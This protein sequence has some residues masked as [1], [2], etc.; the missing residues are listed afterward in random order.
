MSKKSWPILYSKLQSKIGQDFLDIQYL[1]GRDW[2]P[3]DNFT[4]Y[5]PDPWP[6]TEPDGRVKVVFQNGR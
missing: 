3:A 1:F 6:V 5:K 2:E 4:L